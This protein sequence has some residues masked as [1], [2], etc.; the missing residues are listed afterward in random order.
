ME[1]FKAV[2]LSSY[3]PKNDSHCVSLHLCKM[4]NHVSS[5]NQCSLEL[6]SSSSYCTTLPLYTINLQEILSRPKILKYYVV[7]KPLSFYMSVSLALIWRLMYSRGG[8]G[9]LSISWFCWILEPMISVRSE[10]LIPI[11]S[12]VKGT[13]HWK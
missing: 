6:C 9:R 2:Y 11:K 5:K 1:T 12:V 7:F 10:F 13:I 4:W 3:V 8:S